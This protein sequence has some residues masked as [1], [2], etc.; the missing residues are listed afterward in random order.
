MTALDQAI[1]RSRVAAARTTG[2]PWRV[3]PRVK[4]GESRPVPDLLR[5]EFEVTAH[6][7]APDKLDGR[8]ADITAFESGRSPGIVGEDLALVVWA[9]PTGGVI[10]QHDIVQEVVTAPAVGRKYRVSKPPGG[11]RT[12]H[13]RLDLTA[14]EPADG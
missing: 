12:G 6:L 9:N 11:D 13:I 5:T 2:V 14:L 4:K 8:V 3:L 7:F 1:R 10:R